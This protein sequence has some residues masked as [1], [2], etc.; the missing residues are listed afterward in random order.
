MEFEETKL[1][2]AWLVR[3]AKFPDVSGQVSQTFD[4]AEFEAR[5]LCGRF[6]QCNASQ[7]E[8]KG[9]LRGMHF[10]VKPAEQAKLIRCTVGAIRDVIV[11]IRPE[12]PTYLAHFSA[13]LTAES[14]LQLFV[15][16]GFAHGYQTLEDHT[17]VSYQTSDYYNPDTLRGIRFDDPRLGI[18]WPLPVSRIVERGRQW[19][20]L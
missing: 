2:G 10:Q 13:D 17:E 4:A 12:S 11:D 19:P 7:N 1:K 18:T 9:T 3:P 5:G 6:V 14:Q 16:H 15:P 8:L 20:L